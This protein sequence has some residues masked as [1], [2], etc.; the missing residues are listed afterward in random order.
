LGLNLPT[1]AVHDLVV[2]DDDLVVGTHG[3][4]IWILDDLTPI[5]EWSKDIAGRTAHLF[6]PRPAIRWEY[7]SSFS[8]DGIGENPP[9]GAVV[10]YSLKG[11]TDKEITI[12]IL[13][14][15]G[16]VVRTLTSKKE[17]P[18]FEEDDPDA[19]GR[20]RKKPVLTTEAGVQ[21]VAWDLAYES[22]TK[23]K[24]AK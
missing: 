2:K 12:E 21:V 10:A 16:A 18:E 8:D 15:A 20:P 4:S 22:A 5:R 7:R 23:I 19:P 1:V 9:R 3:R 24:N 6:P 14:P 13:D 17:T 11:K